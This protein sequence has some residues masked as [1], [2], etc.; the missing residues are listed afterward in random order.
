[1]RITRLAGI[2]LALLLA[3]TS[4]TLLT[5][6]GAAFAQCPRICPSPT[7]SPP[8]TAPPEPTRTP[9]R[10]PSTTPSPV[11]SDTPTDTPT[12]VPSSTATNTPTPTT[13]PTGT[14]TATSTSTPIAET[15][16]LNEFLPN[17]QNGDS[18][19][20]IFNRGAVS[21]E[22]SGWQLQVV[23]AQTLL[24]PPSTFID[25]KSVV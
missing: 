22:V 13:V 16:A 10:R 25:R 2:L 17:P 4:I 23:G 9:T 21:V 20:E 5:A 7:P 1:M 8:T 11:P 12:P 6:P 24:L 3:L 18:W 14:P 19:I 15:L